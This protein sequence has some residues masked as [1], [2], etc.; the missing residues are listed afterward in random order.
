MPPRPASPIGFSSGRKRR[1]SRRGL[2]RSRRRYH[3]NGTLAA[4]SSRLPGGRGEVGPASGLVLQLEQLE[5]NPPARQQFLV[6]SDLPQAPFVEHQDLI[7]VLNRRE[8]MGN[9]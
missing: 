1:R 4:W 5:V 6:R 2:R 8:T 3:R 7:H 9:G